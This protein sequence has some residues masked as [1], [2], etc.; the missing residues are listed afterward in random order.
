MGT[1]SEPGPGV[2]GLLL[3][4]TPQSQTSL[5]LDVL[6]LEVEECLHNTLSDTTSKSPVIFPV[7]KLRGNCHTP[8]GNCHTP[9][10]NCHTPR[11]NCHTPRGNCHTSHG[12]CYTPRGNYSE[13]RSAKTWIYTQNISPIEV[14]LQKTCP[15]QVLETEH[16]VSLD[17]F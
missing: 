5:T 16:P 8:R 2:C 9:R 12:N 1:T 6:K 11:G 15:C 17:D 14:L 3:N 13:V 7:S 10:G 4:L